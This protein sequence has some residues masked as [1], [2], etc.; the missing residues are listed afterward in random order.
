MCAIGSKSNCGYAFFRN[1]IGKSH[2]HGLIGDT[3]ERGPLESPSHAAMAKLFGVKQ[4]AVAPRAA[5]PG[6]CAIVEPSARD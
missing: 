2:E 4:T 5:P 1:G 3:P 6:N